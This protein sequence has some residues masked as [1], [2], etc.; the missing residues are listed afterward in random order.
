MI[1]RTDRPLAA[2][3]STGWHE[4]LTTLLTPD[5]GRATVCGYDVVA[6]AADVR[7]SIGLAGQYAAVEETLTGRENLEMVG[8][9]YHLGT[10]EARRRADELLD[11]FD[12][13]DAADRM[14]KTYS[15]GMRRRLD[16]A[17]SLTGQPQ[18][19]FLDE[20][21]TGL[22][23]RSRSGL[24]EVIRKLVDDGTSLLL[25]TQYLEEADRLAD[26]ITVIDHGKV[27]AEGTA[28]QLKSR[29]GGDV[30]EFRIPELDKENGQRPAGRRG[31][32]P[33]EPR[34]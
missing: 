13:D 15:G 20:P 1:S 34:S 10:A 18:V 11:R 30:L 14:A 2:K 8:R 19:L 31:G 32:Q 22:D 3:P 25:C 26:A 4:I 33:A 6:E 17:A 5:A 23:P 16:L 12:L 7:R 29:V 27:I 24:W 21:T 28:D 9:L